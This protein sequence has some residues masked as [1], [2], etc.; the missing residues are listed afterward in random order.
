MASSGD[1]I[2]ALKGHID[3]HRAVYKDTGNSR[4]NNKKD[5]VW[6]QETSHA[7]FQELQEEE[8]NR[9]RRVSN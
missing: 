9:W 8:R 3:P 1:G 5:G 7:E 2:S 4:G 6:V